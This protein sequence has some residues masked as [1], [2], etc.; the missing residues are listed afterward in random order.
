[1]SRL[2]PQVTALT[3]ALVAGLAFGKPK[4]GTLAPP[5][6]G[7]DC[8]QCHDAWL[9]K[10]VVHPPVKNG[11]CFA[12]HA[13][14]SATAHTFAL[15]AD[16]KAMCAQCHSTRDTL[17]VLHP[18]VSEG[19]CLTCHDPHGSDHHARLRAPIFETCTSCHPSK[20]M[21]NEAALTKHG[22]LDPQQNP[23]VCVSCHDA[24][25]SDHEKR[26]VAW[27]AVNVCLQCHDQPQKTPAGDTLLD[28][29]AWLEANPKTELRHGP[30][31]EG[32]C[33]DCH[34]PHGTSDW[35]ML[36]GAFPGTPYAPFTGPETYGL[37]FR[38]H[39]Q[40]LVV[41]PK[42]A[43]KPESNVDPALDLAMRPQPQGERLVR[44]GVTG[45]R[46]GDEN[47]HFRHV[48]KLDKGRPCRLCHDVHASQNPKHVRTSTPFGSW[49]F[50]LNYR[51][52]TTGGS[53]WPG[54]HAQRQYDR[55]ARQENPR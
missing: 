7:E 50:K 12:C 49:E 9:G 17:K 3:L 28:M 33:P 53:C 23:R 4:P 24:H 43:E 15:Q 2:S 13:S 30:V 47:L 19:L 35:R 10:K 52:T 32:R 1:M 29:K 25:Q 51:K 21:Q 37:C 36:K 18:P 22:A 40:R 42:L 14:T 6:P 5:G 26:L 39:D 11:L 55:D 48:N 34:E 41:E 8:A 54:C 20:R 27:P 38:C 45:F 16:G 46:N 31:R 44:V